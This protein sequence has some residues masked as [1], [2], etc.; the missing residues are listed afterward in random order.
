VARSILAARGEAAEPV[1]LLLE[2]G[3]PLIAAILGVLKAGKIYVPLDPSYPRGSLSYMLEHSEAG[4]LVT[5]EKNLPL[6]AELAGD[7]RQTLSVDR[8]GSD[9]S[10][11]NAGLSLSAENLAYIFYTSG[12]TGRPKGVVDNHR[13]VLHNIMRYTNGLEIGSDDRLTLLQSCSFSGSVSSLFSAL[14]NGVPIFPFDPRREPPGN[15]AEWLRE[16]KI[17]IYHS[18]PTT[19][20][21]LL[22]AGGRLPDVRIIRLEGDQASPLDV[23]LYKK[24]FSD[25]CILVNGLGAT[26]TGITR[27]YFI[28][29]ETE[30]TGSIVPIGYPVEDIEVML[31]GGSGEQIGFDQVGEIAVKSRHVAVGYW[32]RPDLTGA[33]FQPCLEEDGARIYRTGDL[34]RMRS[35]GCLEHLGRKDFQVKIRG[36]RVEVAEIESVLLRLTQI[37]EAVVVAGDDRYGEKR[38]IAYLVPAYK[39]APTISAVRRFLAERLPDYMIP[40]AFIMLDSLP[41]NA[42]GK[43]DRRALPAPDGARPDL[44]TAFEPPRTP[45][46]QMLAKTWA[47]VLGLE[48]LGINDNFFELGGQSLDAARIISQTGLSVQAFLNALTIRGMA[49]E[50]ERVRRHPTT[51]PDSGLLVPIQPQ[52]NAPPLFC[53]AGHDD[54]L[55]G[56]SNL[57]RHLPP[58]QP[59]FGFAPPQLGEDGTGYRLEDLA[60]RYVQA[61]CRH[62]PEGPY[63]LAGHCFGGRVVYE[64]ARQLQAQGQKVTLLAMLECFNEHWLRNL[65]ATALLWHKLSHLVRRGAFHFGSLARVGAAGALSY[66]RERGRTVASDR[67]ERAQQKAFDQCI[68]T[69]RPLPAALR[70]VRY[71]N[72]AAGRNCVPQPYSGCALLLRGSDPRAGQYPAP[73]MGWKGLLTGEVE[74]H[75][76]PDRLQGLLAKSVVQQVAHHVRLAIAATRHGFVAPPEP[77]IAPDPHAPQSTIP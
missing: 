45:T 30:I 13:N 5:D 66:L 29:K 10:A 48:Q 68:R 59:V 72:R 23:A 20:R 55:L 52:G 22:S 61:M 56:F 40:S 65:A 18:V 57:A 41:L 3:A 63:L 31:L 28:N 73:L 42:N 58:D 74:I 4:M 17:T 15:L 71:A 12:S 53:V 75:D 11:E 49:T 46:E 36:H 6:A 16:N 33:A 24:H 69:G 27:R 8:I 47:E 76:I 38:I 54:E 21:Q 7:S 14:L 51:A 19:F 64:M 44:D 34:G 37:N 25:E 67:H 9:V 43:I 50:I 70:D 39:P 60:A 35:D 2:Q 32:R 62:Q 1:A 26:E 77:P